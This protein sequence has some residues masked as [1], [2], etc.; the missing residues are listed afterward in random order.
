[1][2]YLKFTPEYKDS[3]LR[4]LCEQLDPY[5]MYSIATNELDNDPELLHTC[6]MQFKER[7]LIQQYSGGRIASMV[8]TADAIDFL[9]QGGFVFEETVLL[10]QLDKVILE[11]EKLQSESNPKKYL[12]RIRDITN[13]VKDIMATYTVIKGDA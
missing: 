13:V 7:G 10:H 2:D 1:M 5:H 6:L 8:L 12:G 3:I 4:K 9:R 11:L